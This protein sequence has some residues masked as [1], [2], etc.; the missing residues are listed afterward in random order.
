MSTAAIA[1]A[2]TSWSAMAQAQDWQMPAATTP[3][4]AATSAAPPFPGNATP[5]HTAQGHPQQG[6]PQQGY[7]QQGYP[8]QGYPAH[9]Y[10]AQGYPQQGHP[11]QGYPQQGYPVQGHPA[12]G[13][14]AQ[15]H[16]A[17]AGQ[18]EADDAGSGVA[19]D[20]AAGT[21]FPLGLGPHLSLEVPGRILLEAELGW[22]PP[23][24]GSAIVGII[25][26]VNDNSALQP[27]IESAL[28]DSF[29]ARF[30]A[31][32]RPFPSAGFELTGG[33]T[34][35]AVSGDA[36]PEVV[37]NVVDGELEDR[38]A[39]EVTEGIPV[40]ATLHNFHV[41]VGWRWLA[42]NDHLVIRA[43]LGYTQTLAASADVELPG[44]LADLQSEINPMFDR[45][46]DDLLT[47][48][49]KLPVLSAN[50]GYRF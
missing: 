25:S 13:H 5:S 1:C 16:P 10:P 32:W 33:Y 38:L 9:G 40:S 48:D 31:G 4:P 2:I 28:A 35:I 8:Q 39:A 18:L 19:F 49:V 15:R 3:P 50:M 42:A 22:M 46:V 11:Q 34:L 29:V 24:Y 6:H 36:S 12:Q 47:S 27:V 14:P 37:G 26:S 43:R 44:G 17:D 45:K 23:A 41:A 20:L 7:P 21:S 30:G